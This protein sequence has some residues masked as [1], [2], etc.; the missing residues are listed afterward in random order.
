MN[1]PILE[2]KHLTMGF[3]GLELFS[4]INISVNKGEIFGIIGTNGSGKTTLFNII[5][6]IYR[7]LSGSVTYKGRNISGLPPHK[8]ARMGIGRCFQMVAP[9]ESMTPLENIKVARAN[10]GRSGKGIKLPIDEIMALTHL[11]D[12]KDITTNNL[13]LPDKKN[14]E[15]ARALACNPEIIL[16]DEVSCGLS[17]EEIRER[18]KLMKQLAEHGITIIVIEHIMMFIKEICD[19]VVVLHAGELISQGKPE[20]VIADPKV[21]DAYLGGGKL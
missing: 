7:A 18:M 12:K 15:I 11:E 19:R 10:A 2:L 1:E 17:G 6:G 16:F 8:I 4:D 20:E 5:C 21:I 3:G 9:F 13:S 14:V